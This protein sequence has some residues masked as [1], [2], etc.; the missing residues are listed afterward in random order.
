MNKNLVQIDLYKLGPNNCFIK[1]NG[2]SM[3]KLNRPVGYANVGYT[4]GYARP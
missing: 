1:S 4:F 3:F 2:F